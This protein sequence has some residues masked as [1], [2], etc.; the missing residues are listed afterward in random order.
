[1]EDSTFCILPCVLRLIPCRIIAAKDTGTETL[2]FSIAFTKI[3]NKASNGFNICFVVSKEGILFTCRSFS[4]SRG[5][6][7]SN[8]IENEEQLVAAYDGFLGDPKSDSFIDYYNY[9][10]EAIQF[11]SENS[12]SELLELDNRI[13]QPYA[14]RV[15]EAD[16]YL[17]RIE[18]TKVNTLEMLF[19]AEEL[20]R[21]AFE[22]EKKNEELLEKNDSISSNDKEIV[23][24]ETK[25]MLN[26]PEKMIK[27]L[28]KERGIS[29]R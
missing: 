12:A 11:R 25:A 4:N 2:S 16:E 9:I 1:M 23:T 21:I 24:A 27:Q 8:I 28:K 19:E 17:F 3:M 5:Y 26:D 15:I 13:R 20:E 14:I 10:R 6:Y 7:I 29:V 22:T 18:P